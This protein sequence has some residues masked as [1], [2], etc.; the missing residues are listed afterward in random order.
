MPLEVIITEL[1][2][3]IILAV[4]E[5]IDELLTESLGDYLE[6]GTEIGCSVV[7]VVGIGAPEGDYAFLEHLK[8]LTGRASV[9]EELGVALNEDVK[10]KE[11]L[12]QALGLV[13]IT[14]DVGCD[15]HNASSRSYD[16]DLIDHSGSPGGEG[17]LEKK[18]VS[19]FEA[20]VVE[21]FISAYSGE[22]IHLGTEFDVRPGSAIR[23][24]ISC[25]GVSDSV[26]GFFTSPEKSLGIIT[27]S[28]E[29]GGSDYRIDTLITP[30]IQHVK[31][32]T[33]AVRTVIYT[34]EKMRVEIDHKI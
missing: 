7:H 24:P 33:D 6:G 31:G 20:E 15:G 26:V 8:S 2:D 17:H 29:V 25:H 11:F 12:N 22:K 28:I 10:V 30:C 13:K 27:C 14:L 34:W 21:T 5:V 23:R 16:I 18:E 3:Y 9:K 4:G 32:Q 19:S 1:F